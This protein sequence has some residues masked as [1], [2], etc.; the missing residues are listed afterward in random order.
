MRVIGREIVENFGVSH[1]DSRDILQVWLN[2]A[3]AAEWRMPHDIKDRYR[4]ASILGG[5][6]VVFDI[7]GGNYRI[8]TVVDYQRQIVLVKKIGTHSE[9]DTWRIL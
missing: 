7:K 9:Y 5:K 3:K 1:A 8:W 2:E 4:S 6:N